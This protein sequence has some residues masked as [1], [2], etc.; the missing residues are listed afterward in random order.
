[1]PHGSSFI[2]P[3]LPPRL[4]VNAGDLPGDS[5]LVPSEDVHRSQEGQKVST[6]ICLHT[7]EE[8]RPDNEQE[9][10]I[11]R[12]EMENGRM[13]DEVSML[14]TEVTAL[15]TTIAM[16]IAQQNGHSAML[17]GHRSLLMERISPSQYMDIRTESTTPSIPAPPSTT[18][19]PVLFEGG[20]VPRPPNPS[21]DSYWEHDFFSF[22]EY[23]L[24]LETYAS[25]GSSSR[26][27]SEDHQ[28]L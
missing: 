18:P 19:D 8:I 27:P 15:K 5:G 3:I 23:G 13:K 14:R 9:D 20:M 16:L 28:E 22:G 10:Q 17:E 2:L 21:D 12:L 24:G 26:H 4:S 1:V 25:A 6:G 11:S 7:A